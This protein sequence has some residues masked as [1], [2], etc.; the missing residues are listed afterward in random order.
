MTDKF[1]EKEKNRQKQKGAGEYTPAKVAKTAGVSVRTIQR[2]ADAG[3][4]PFVRDNRGWRLFSLESLVKALEVKEA[5]ESSAS[6]N[7]S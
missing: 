3:I 5:K 1:F 7:N 4:L 2:W 6:R